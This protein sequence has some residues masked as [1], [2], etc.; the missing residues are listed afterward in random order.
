MK[1]FVIGCET[2]GLVS[3]ITISLRARRKPCRLLYVYRNYHVRQRFTKRSLSELAC[4]PVTTPHSSA[5][6]ISLSN[7]FRPYPDV[8]LGFN[9]R[10]VG[11]YPKRMRCL[12]TRS[13]IWI[14]YESKE[15][16]FRFEV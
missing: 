16:A 5:C 15:L 11:W 2:R 4:V 1:V 14:S 13:A 3:I 7:G 10:Y 9:L 12:L 6:E 8:G